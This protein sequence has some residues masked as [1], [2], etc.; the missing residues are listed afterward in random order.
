MVA[1]AAVHYKTSL[2][3]IEDPLELF[4]RDDG[5]VVVI[6]KS[7]T[8]LYQVFPPIVKPTFDVDIS[9]SP[10]PSLLCIIHLPHLSSAEV[11]LEDGPVTNVNHTLKQVL[12][13]ISTVDLVYC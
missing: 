2:I 6:G 1:F 11:F 10:Y 8:Q 12:C 3:N 5:I 9:G 13:T 4:V 7:K